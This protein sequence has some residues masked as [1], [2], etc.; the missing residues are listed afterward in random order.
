M[1]DVET[2][3]AKARILVA[4]DEEDVRELCLRTLR[5]RGYQV[6]G[7]ANGLAAIEA[8][9]REPFDLFLTDI[10]MPG[11]TGLE[12]CRCI[13]ELSPE[14]TSV[15]I[16][17][18]GTTELAIEALKA[19]VG[20][21]IIKP[22]T[23]EQLRTAI[24]RALER[25]QLELENARLRALIPL[26]ELSKAFMTTV[27][28]N[29]LLKRVVRTAVEETNADRCSLML[30]D[31]KRGELRIEAAEGLPAEV[32]TTARQRIGEGISGWVAEHGEAQIIQ[33]DPGDD[34]RFRDAPSWESVETAICLPLK[35]KDRVIGVLN[36]A[37]G[38]EA[39]SFRQSEVELLSVLGS[40]AAIAID[41]ARLFREIQEAYRQV[42]ELDHMKSEFI[43][44]AAHEL[45][46]PL[47][48]VLAYVTLLEDEISEPLK[49]HLEVV[50]DAA[51]QLKSII[52]DM[53]S[54]SHIEAGQTRLR[55]ESISI[56]QAIA[57]VMA[58]VAQIADSRGHTVITN[59]P[60]DLPT[61]QADAE[62][63]HLVFSN[64][65][66]NAVKF[67]PE[68]GRIEISARVEG[69]DVV[70]SV[71]DNGIGIPEEARE[72]IF[73]RFYQVEESLRREYP[74][75]GLGLSVV[76]AMVELHEGKIWVESELGE[77]STFY[78]RFPLSG[79]QTE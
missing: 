67:T 39:E 15:V 13:R 1:G 32:V 73:D 55:L 28:L 8:V 26:F 77:G 19:G 79:P 4:D 53:L 7:V 2:S 10:N 34:P 51:M 35:V 12:A 63:L 59:L 69:Q 38:P 33:G 3:V 16:T 76:K 36:V 64:L 24:E 23:P 75:I 5:N 37:K 66:S 61:V 56:D 18:F 22:F 54:L 6:S 41:N 25:R 49:E 52:D 70:I 48:V 43:S 29:A 58:E 72:K 40:Q 47:A 17:G 44:I 74:G 68:G 31:E 78:C 57:V 50:V 45:R 71:S 9:R 27:D 65:L 11:M 42:S 62:K 14:T 20:E 21:F 30:L 46:T 60:D